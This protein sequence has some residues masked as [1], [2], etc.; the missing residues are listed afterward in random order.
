MFGIGASE[1][2]TCERRKNL[3]IR[4]DHKEGCAIRGI[5]EEEERCVEGVTCTEA[6]VKRKLC[7][8]DILGTMA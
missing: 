1:I 5:E 4:D 2:A 8:G 6:F 7:K 3:G